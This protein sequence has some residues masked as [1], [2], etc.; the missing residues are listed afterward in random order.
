MTDDEF[1]GTTKAEPTWEKACD[2]CGA[3]VAR[4]RGE[5]DVDCPGCGAWYN[6]GGQRLRDDWQENASTWDEDVDDLEGYEAMMLR[7]EEVG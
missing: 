4:Y 6:A 2:R 1:Y 5:R 7:Y 3:P